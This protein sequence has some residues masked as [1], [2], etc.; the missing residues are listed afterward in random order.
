LQVPAVLYNLPAF[1]GPIETPVV[2]SVL[3]KVA[4]I[5]GIKDSSGELAT[6][7]ALSNDRALNA[8]RIM[9][10]DGSLSEALDRKLCDCV[11]SGV[12]G[13]LPE[14]IQAL[15][16]GN[17]AGDCQRKHRVAVS[18]SELLSHLDILPIP[19]GLKVI[20]EMRFDIPAQFSLPLSP[21]RQHQIEGFRSWFGDWWPQAEANLGRI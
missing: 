10:N 7:E 17:Q 18:L 6:L 13:V 3:R 8:V 14:L 12:A 21:Q 19:W 20:A 4:A 1:S 9:G 11:I 16:D 15:W 5:A 2:L